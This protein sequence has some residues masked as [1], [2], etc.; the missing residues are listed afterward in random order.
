LFAGGEAASYGSMLREKKIEAIRLRTEER[1]SLKEICAELS[2][3]QSTA[4]RWLR[5]LPSL[6][7]GERA[8]K[9][10]RGPKPVTLQT[11]GQSSRFWDSTKKYSLDDKCRIAEAA[12]LFRLTLY[13]FRTYS[14][15][16]DGDRIDW[17]IEKNGEYFKLQVKW[18]ASSRTGLP[19]LNLRRSK[20]HS[21]S[22]PYE[23]GDYDFIVG[24]WLYNDTAY[25]FSRREV[26]KYRSN[27]AVSVSAAEA[28]LKINADDSS[29]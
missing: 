16:F 26:A 22:T 5:G 9:R 18:L 24:Y 8:S 14:S 23:E 2:I 7:E 27:I 21:G 19:I 17:L 29:R 13:G 1:R 15:V 6:T 11:R 3:S 4:S 20:G 10:H 25:V 12:V 28:W